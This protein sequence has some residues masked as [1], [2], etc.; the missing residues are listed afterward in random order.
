LNSHPRPQIEV[1]AIKLLLWKATGELRERKERVRTNDVVMT[2]LVAL[3]LIGGDS[4]AIGLSHQATLNG[5]RRKGEDTGGSNPHVH[6]RSQ[7]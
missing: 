6:L 5:L 4:K 2:L 7:Q 3:L 1:A